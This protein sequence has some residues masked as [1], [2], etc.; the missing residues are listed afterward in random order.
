[1]TILLYI[2]AGVE[3]PHGNCARTGFRSARFC[4]KE[5]AIF[6]KA[7]FPEEKDDD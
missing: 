2:V 3:F 6:P 5:R 4:S 1:M 7:R